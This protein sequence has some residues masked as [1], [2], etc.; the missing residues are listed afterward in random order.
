[1]IRYLTGEEKQTSRWLWQEAFPEDSQGFIDYYYKRK[2]ADNR[3]LVKEDE[4]GRLLSM[5]HLNPYRVMVKG[6]LWELNYIV[7]VATAAD[8]RR[9]GHMRD[10]LGKLLLDLHDEGAPFCY[11]MPASEGIYLPFGFRFVFDQP[12]WQIKKRL[13]EETRRLEFQLSEEAG[14]QAGTAAFGSEGE[15][16]D[17]LASWVNRWLDERFQVYAVRD[18]EYMERLEE[19]LDSEA[20]QVYGWYDGDGELKALQAFWGIGKREQRFLYSM[21][22][23][24]VEPA[25]A[26]KT[27]GKSGSLRSAIMA[28]ITNA[29]RMMEAIGLNEEAPC[30]EMEVL[31][32]IRDKLIPGNQGLWRWKLNG[33]GSCLIP[34]PVGLAGGSLFS[35]EVLDIDVATLTSWLFGYERLENLMGE[36]E[37]RPPWWC[38]FAEP[39]ER[40]FLDEVV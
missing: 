36:Q 24:W 18:R 19:E 23:D 12:L 39:I 22:P 30:S 6:R 38:R 20:G 37:E 33:K 3:I 14:T 35:T 13:P 27:E 4:A 16:R 7:G 1:M 17:Y 32:R 40:L 15:A 2:T 26:D 34:E 9:Q 5:A 8:S 10:M 25:K 31:I 11:L 29:A 21:E 28:R